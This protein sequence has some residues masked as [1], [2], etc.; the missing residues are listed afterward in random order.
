MQQIIPLLSSLLYLAGGEISSSDDRNGLFM[1][2]LHQKQIN[3]FMIMIMPFNAT[4]ILQETDA[5]HMKHT[6]LIP[7]LSN[8]CCT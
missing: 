7:Y 4:V 8:A 2:T 3:K 1:A 5:K 6:G